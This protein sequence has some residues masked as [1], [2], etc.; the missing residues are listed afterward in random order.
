MD[1]YFKRLRGETTMDFKD[2]MERATW[3]FAQGFIVTFC[4]LA[5][6]L[7]SAPNLEEVKA[8]VVAALMASLMAGFSAL[9]TFVKQTA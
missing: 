8:L 4:T 5:P 2:L 7:L 3:T 9:K 1:N 6:G